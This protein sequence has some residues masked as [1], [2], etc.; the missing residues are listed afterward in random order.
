MVKSL[1]VLII[2][3]AGNNMN[4]MLQKQLDDEYDQLSIFDKLSIFFGIYDKHNIIFINLTSN[5]SNKHE[6]IRYLASLPINQNN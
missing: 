1:N 5:R 3:P 4:E 6:L 2:H